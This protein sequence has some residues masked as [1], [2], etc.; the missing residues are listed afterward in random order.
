MFDKPESRK[1]VFKSLPA[2][3]SNYDQLDKE[4]Q[5][6][7]DSLGVLYEQE[8]SEIEFLDSFIDYDD[9]SIIYKTIEDKEKSEQETSVDD[10]EIVVVTDKAEE[11][12]RE[13]VINGSETSKKISREKWKWWKS[14]GR[15]ILRRFS[16]SCL[17]G[18]FSQPRSRYEVTTERRLEESGSETE[19]GA[20]GELVTVKSFH[21]QQEPLQQVQEVQQVRIK[22]VDGPGPDNSGYTQAVNELE[23]LEKLILRDSL[24]ETFLKRR[25]METIR[26]ESDLAFFNLSYDMVKVDRS[27]LDNYYENL[28][29][30]KRIQ[31]LYENVK[32]PSDSGSTAETK[33]GCDQYY[34]NIPQQTP[35]LISSNDDEYESYDF[36]EEG[37]YQNIMFTNGSSSIKGSDLNSKVDALQ[38]CINEVN[39]IIKVK[40]NDNPSKKVYVTEGLS[41]PTSSIKEEKT[42]TKPAANTPPQK[43]VRSISNNFKTWALGKAEHP[44]LD[45]NKLPRQK[46][47]NTEAFS[48]EERNVVSEFLKTFKDELKTN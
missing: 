34:E 39:D 48:L 22:N 46:P 13:I 32:F 41:K 15:L 36:G 10:H 25:G 16:C 38:Q 24:R 9:I 14:K 18:R 8:D 33:D 35:A 7:S 6:L 20:G 12:T 17:R 23:N 28:D 3:D 5:Q 1:N 31:N 45:P 4:L 2:L 21:I 30:K 42:E 19:G 37:I 11:G 47:V 26:E 27:V 43:P 44:K 40:P 29:Q